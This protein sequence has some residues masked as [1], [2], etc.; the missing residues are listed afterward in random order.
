MALG[1][2]AA[3]GMGEG[4]GW[5]RKSGALQRDSM[6]GSAPHEWH[7][8]L[9]QELRAIEMQFYT[10]HNYVLRECAAGARADR[11]LAHPNFR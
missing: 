6:T 9:Y 10:L 4:T 11:I 5:R 7:L 2:T 8:A 3:V 1:K